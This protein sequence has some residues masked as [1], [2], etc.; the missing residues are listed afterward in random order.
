MELLWFEDFLALVQTEN[1]SRAAEQRNVTQPAFSRR[2]RVLEDWVGVP[3]FARHSHGVTLTAAG[4]ALRAGVEETVRRIHQLRTEAREASGKEAAS[5]YF[6]ATHALSFTFFSRWMRE[7]E[8]DTAP[9]GT[10]RLVS[11]T[12]Q[13]CEELM[14]R[15]QAQF[16]ICHHHNAAPEH[17]ELAQFRSA[18]VGEDILSPVT[19]PDSDGAPLWRLDGAKDTPFLGYSGE[20][21]LGRILAAQNFAA[22]GVRLQTVLSAQLATAL[23]TM[24]LDG[25]GVAWVPRSLVEPEIAAGRLV[26]AGD[27]SWDVPLEIRLFRS[28]ARQSAAAEAFWSGIAQRREDAAG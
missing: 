17:F 1:F 20:S 10:I 4:T 8:R 11:D 26:R 24:A 23:M 25:R 27:E 5:L 2:I 14:L 6:A 15:G 3:L 12:M 9:L 19:A 22:R 28:R 21:G 13:A 7:L 18:Q 16:L